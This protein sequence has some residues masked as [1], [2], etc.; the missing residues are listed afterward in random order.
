MKGEI[1][2][3][4]KIAINGFGRIGR[5]VF[6]R[7][8][9]SGEFEVVAI[10]DLSSA[11]NLAYL[12]KYDSAQGVFK[13]HEISHDDNNIIFDGRIIPVYS[14]K[15]PA[16]IPWDKNEAELVMECT[17]RFRT[18]DSAGAH[19]GGSVKGVIISAP[20]DKDTPTFVYGVNSD[21]LT[22]EDTVV[23]G[24]SCTTNCLAPVMKV[25]DENFGV[26]GGFMT[27]VHA[28]TNDQTNLDMVKEKD[29]RRGRASAANIIPTTTGAA[30]A[31]SLVLPKMKG[32]MHGISMR[33]PVIDGSVVD[34][35]ITL[36]NKVTIE[37]INNAM[38]EA[39]ETNLKG[40]MEYSDDLL[41]SSDIIGST[42]GAVFESNQ[43]I[44]LDNPDGKQYVK[45]LAWYDNEYGY[46]CQFMRLARLM[47]EKLNLV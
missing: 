45:V 41:V 43:T 16:D 12:L 24:A 38:K 47:A 8:V 37:E 22:S 29:F 36:N 34:L 11:A 27:T 26:E 15:N 33:V 3:S 32:R 40:V 46:T 18:K 30:K 17:G 31:L 28:Y 6:R 5:L 4:I 23:S 44:I 2:M 7:A 14:E 20:A 13:G 25:L 1:N 35:T 21:E 10:N 9:E 19:L 39:S 42:Y